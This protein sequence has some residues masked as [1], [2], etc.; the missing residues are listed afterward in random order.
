[1]ISA[2][3]TNAPLTLR[4]AQAGDAPALANLMAD[5]AVFAGLLQLPHPS[6]A[7]WRE[8]L[9]AQE[10]ATSGELHLVALRGGDLL[11]SAGLH[12]APQLRRRHAAMLG[13]SVAVPAQRQGVGT[14]LMAALL[15]YADRWAGFTRIEL[16]VF[17]D[18]APAIALYRRCGFE[19]EGVLR[20]Y[21]MR[22]GAVADVL[23]M[24]RLKGASD[25]HESRPIHA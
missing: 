17:T 20:R 3:P 8:R 13:I 24:A 10:R 21:A 1:M 14:A 2:M 11:G 7:V 9:L 19:P 23:T 6:E 25:P 5:E 15:D 4:R 18:N 12:P 16:T 22:G